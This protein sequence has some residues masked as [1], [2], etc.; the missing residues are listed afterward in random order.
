MYHSMEQVEER[1][2]EREMDRVNRNEAT[3]LLR[4]G[5]KK[6]G[7]EGGEQSTAEGERENEKQDQDKVAYTRKTLRYRA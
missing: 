1:T 5:E 6:G 2:R 4:S 7:G 3:V